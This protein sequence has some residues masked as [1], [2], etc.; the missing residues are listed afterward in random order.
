MT[1]LVT[2]VKKQGKFRIFYLKFTKDIEMKILFLT[3]MMSIL[4]PGAFGAAEENYMKNIV[5]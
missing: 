1:L 5:T 2:K 3:L 4:S